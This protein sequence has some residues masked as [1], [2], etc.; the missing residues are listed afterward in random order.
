MTRTCNA[1]QIARTKLAVDAEI[2]KRELPGPFLHLQPNPDRPDVLRLK[3]SHLPDDRAA[4]F[5]ES[6]HGA[7]AVR[8]F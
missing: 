2:E 4:D 8:V 1:G 7:L 3:R 5:I 6:R